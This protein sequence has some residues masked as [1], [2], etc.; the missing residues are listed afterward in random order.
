[1]EKAGLRRLFLCR[2]VRLK[3]FDGDLARS[4]VVGEKF[5]PTSV[6]SGVRLKFFD[7]VLARFGL[8]GEKFNPTPVASSGFLVGS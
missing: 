5:N 4:G 8:A 7:E 3:F 1:M 2:G 6:K